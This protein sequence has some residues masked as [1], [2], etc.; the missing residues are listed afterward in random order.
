MIPN[1]WYAVLP[2]KA[3][4]PGQITAVKRMG[5]ELAFFRNEKGEPACVTDQCSHRGAAEF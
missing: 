4:K 3:V 1:K 2:S 5:Q